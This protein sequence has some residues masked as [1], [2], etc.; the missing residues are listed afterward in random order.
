M[1]TVRKVFVLVLQ[2][3]VLRNWQK[4]YIITSLK[5]AEKLN[6]IGERLALEYGVRY[7]P[8][9]FKKKNGYK[10]SIELS[11][12]HNLYRQNYCGCVFSKEEQPPN[13]LSAIIVM[14]SE[15]ATLVNPEH[16]LNASTPRFVKEL[17]R[18]MFDRPAH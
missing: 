4:T 13:V 11:G 6:E 1:L 8:S 2:T 18:V 3:P 7:L 10:R 17:G 5:N 14:D 12:E 15:R 9:D 16:C